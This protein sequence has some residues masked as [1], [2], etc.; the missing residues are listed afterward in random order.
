MESVLLG[1]GNDVLESVQGGEVA[2]ESCLF[3]FRL[4]VLG[5]PEARAVDAE[6]ERENGRGKG[7]RRESEERERQ[8]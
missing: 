8:E 2:Q 3:H 6:R 4:G 5:K 7:E 1:G